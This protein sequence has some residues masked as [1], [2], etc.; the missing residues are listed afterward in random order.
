MSTDKDFAGFAEALDRSRSPST[1]TVDDLLLLAAAES[2][3]AVEA[4]PPNAVAPLAN[5]CGEVVI[6]DPDHASACAFRAY[7]FIARARELLAA[8]R[9]VGDAGGSR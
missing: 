4:L 3:M 6:A 7:G 5:N 1:A 9:R 2:M 8:T